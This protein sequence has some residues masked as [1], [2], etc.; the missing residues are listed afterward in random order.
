MHKYGDFEDSDFLNFVAGIPVFALITIGISQ[1]FQYRE[2]MRFYELQK[3]EQKNRQ[4]LSILNS[5]SNSILVVQSSENHPKEPNVVFRN[6]QS[7]W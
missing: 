5:Q 1:I 6:E 4:L 2:L 3:A 7:L